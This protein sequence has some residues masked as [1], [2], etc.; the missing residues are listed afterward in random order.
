M[1][2]WRKIFPNCY[3]GKGDFSSAMRLHEKQTRSVG[4]ARVPEGDDERQGGDFGIRRTCVC[5]FVC[6]WCA[7]GVERR[8][9]GQSR[10]RA[11]KD[12]CVCVVVPVFRCWY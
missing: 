7:Q 10:N 12:V 11:G 3:G 9:G 5:L 8:V 2:K 1:E 6:G 4:V